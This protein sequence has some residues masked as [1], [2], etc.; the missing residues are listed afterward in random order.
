MVVFLVPQKKPMSYTGYPYHRLP[1]ANPPS[2]CTSAERSSTLFCHAKKP[3]LPKPDLQRA[4]F[5]Y[6]VINRNLRIINEPTFSIQLRECCWFIR[7]K[8]RNLVD[9]HVEKHYCAKHDD[10]GH[11]DSDDQIF[12]P[13]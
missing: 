5:A 8:N 2:A 10:A 6:R 12:D 11:Y 4:G 7:P 1:C 13:M 3:G 9:D